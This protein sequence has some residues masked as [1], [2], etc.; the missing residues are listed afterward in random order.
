MAS[1]IVTVEEEPF[2]V[3]KSGERIVLQ[4]VFQ[5]DYEFDRANALRLAEEI[6]EKCK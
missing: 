5:A 3:F 4:A 1:E 2:L 6:R